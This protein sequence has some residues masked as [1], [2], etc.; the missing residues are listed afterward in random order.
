MSSI[1]PNSST[2]PDAY[3]VFATGPYDP[4]AARVWT[5]GLGQL[6]STPGGKHD[7]VCLGG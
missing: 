1:M 2:P 5:S 7:P 6:G 4:V 3:L